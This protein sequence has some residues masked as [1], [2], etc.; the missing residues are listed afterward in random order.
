LLTP[1][2][3]GVAAMVL[4]FS[5]VVLAFADLGL[6]AALVQRRDVTPV[7]TSTVF[8][9]TIATGAVMAA[10]GWFAAPPIAAFYGTPQVKP[11]FEAMSVTFLIASLATTQTALLTREMQF[12]TLELRNITGTIA[13]S[14]VGIT[15]AATGAGAWAII[16]QQLANSVAAT[17]LIWV[18]S[19]WRPKLLFSRASLRKLGYFGANVFGQRLLYYAHRNSD[20]LLIGKFVGSAALGAYS[21]AYN[22]MLLPFSRIA[23][24][25]QQVMYPALAVKQHDRLWLETAWVRVTRAVGSITIPAL[26]GLIV[27]APDF[28]D[29]VLGPHWHPVVRLLQILAWVGLL[30]SLQTLNG[31][32][33]QALDQTGRLFRF[34]V[35]FFAGHLAGFVIGVHWGV[36]GIATAYAITSTIL[37]PLF[38]ILTA[39]LLGTSVWTIPTALLGIVT[40]AAIMTASVAVARVQLMHHAD[41]SAG[42]RLLILIMLGALIYVP[43][44]RLASPELFVDLRSLRRRKRALSLDNARPET[45][46]SNEPHRE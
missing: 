2:D 34:T 45:S 16:G 39:R 40:A 10:A 3:F 27:V 12:R 31:D 25:I 38:A 7:D 36:V 13:G 20:N 11:L 33:F 26:A 14:V 19:S 6:G 43:L 30:Q 24:P 28:V 22:V 46:P 29:A 21:L 17:T 4:V 8:W 23:G 42:L 44:C 15:L 18:A 41:L 37:E 32:I 5:G 9:L 35:L 1:H